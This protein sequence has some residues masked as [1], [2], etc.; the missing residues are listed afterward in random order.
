MR[1]ESTISDGKVPTT[2]QKLKSFFGKLI[3]KLSQSKNEDQ[4]FDQKID[5]E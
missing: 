5:T 4:I 1:R 2:G 3:P